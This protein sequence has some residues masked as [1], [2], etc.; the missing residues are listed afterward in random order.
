MPI[1]KKWATK[2]TERNFPHIVE[3]A[4]APGGL[5]KRLDAMHEWLNAREIL[6]RRWRGRY[7]EG[8][9]YIRW[10][11]A[12]AAT[13]EAFLAVFGGDRITTT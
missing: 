9:F 2:S 5:G 6:S 12:E 7:N 10:C 4:I 13:A 3:M 11:F 1:T 8:T